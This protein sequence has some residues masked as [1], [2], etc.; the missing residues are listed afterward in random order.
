MRCATW[1]DWGPETPKKPQGLL[2]ARGVAGAGG[3][4]CGMAD[5]CAA[6]QSSCQE[7]SHDAMPRGAGVKQPISGGAIVGFS[8]WRPSRR[9]GVCGEHDFECEQVWGARG[10]AVF[11]L[12]AG[13]GRVYSRR[14]RDVLRQAKRTKKAGIVGKYGA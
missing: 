9:D 8:H 14:R 6:R 4:S 11:A 2:G 7:A 10:R 3:W 1:P 5:E 13:E 12:S